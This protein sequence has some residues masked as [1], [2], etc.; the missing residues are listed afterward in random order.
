MP[1]AQT[2]LLHPDRPL[3]LDAARGAE[4]RVDAGIVW[5]TVG[6][7]AGDVFLAAGECYRVPGKGRVLA[8]AMRATASVRLE[9]AA[10]RAIPIRF[11]AA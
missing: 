1:T 8:E 6:G 4:L 3:C 10:R 2:L 11:E 7:V 5:I 9:S